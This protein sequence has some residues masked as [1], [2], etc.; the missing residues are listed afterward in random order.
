VLVG[1]CVLVGVLGEC[2][3]QF[4]EYKHKN[5]NISALWCV[6]KMEP[7]TSFD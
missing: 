7:I 5:S 3:Q 2:N 1:V 4:T 6:A